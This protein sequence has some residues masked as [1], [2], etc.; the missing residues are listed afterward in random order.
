M[1]IR[2][3]AIGIAFAMSVGLPNVRAFERDPEIENAFSAGVAGGSSNG[4]SIQIAVKSL[5]M[6]FGSPIEIYIRYRNDSKNSILLPIGRE[7]IGSLEGFTLHVT[8]AGS[9]SEK[10]KGMVS[11]FR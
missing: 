11:T 7:D 1:M 4:L 2:N 3:L 8:E 9:D 6:P 5:N 10:L